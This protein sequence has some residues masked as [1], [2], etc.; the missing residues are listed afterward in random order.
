MNKAA[1]KPQLN[2]TAKNTQRRSLPS[3]DKVL[4]LMIVLQILQR[5][6]PLQRLIKNK[7]HPK[8]LNIFFKVKIKNNKE[9]RLKYTLSLKMD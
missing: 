7:V 5:A 3:N 4:D 6:M 9:I 2:R 8:T 1:N